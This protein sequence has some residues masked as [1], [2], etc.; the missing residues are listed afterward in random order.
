MTVASL[1]PARRRMWI[2]LLAFWIAF[3]AF[4]VAYMFNVEA[5]VGNIGGLALAV[6][7]ACI[8]LFHLDTARRRLWI[9]L[10][11]TLIGASLL[12]M[13]YTV[14]TWRS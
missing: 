10:A 4:S 5:D 2:V 8:A 3:A 7:S 11:N 13:V 9:V 12:L 1:Q 6:G 14:A